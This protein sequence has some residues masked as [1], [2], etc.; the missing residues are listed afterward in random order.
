M[1]SVL[2]ASGDLEVSL[3]LRSQSRRE[4]S[5]VSS[6]KKP[7]LL[8]SKCCFPEA[9]L[10]LPLLTE[11]RWTQRRAAASLPPLLL[12]GQPCLSVGMSRSAGLP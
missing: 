9:G 12:V 1:S 11:K 2:S 3:G 10:C 8:S 6:S 7:R 4:W 5:P